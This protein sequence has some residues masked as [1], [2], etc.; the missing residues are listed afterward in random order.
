[1]NDSRDS[2]DLT[3]RLSRDGPTDRPETLPGEVPGLPPASLP[4]N[5]A[6]R[7]GDNRSTSEFV[8]RMHVHVS[9]LEFAKMGGADMPG[10][11]GVWQGDTGGAAQM[12][13]AIR[14]APV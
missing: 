3:S 11:A 2:S 7:S 14:V 5:L 6:A 8:L 10:S 1:M 9:G 13:A 4:P 12:T